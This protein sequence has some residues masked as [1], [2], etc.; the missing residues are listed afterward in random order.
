M[1]I[2]AIATD[3]QALRNKKAAILA[4]RKTIR[5]QKLKPLA[6]QQSEL[7]NEIRQATD[8]IRR[9][10]DK[11][12]K[13]QLLVIAEQ[14]K[15]VS[16]KRDRKKARK[17]TSRIAIDYGRVSRNSETPETV[18]QLAS[19]LHEKSRL[20]ERMIKEITD[21]KRQLLISLT[22]AQLEDLHRWNMITVSLDL[23]QGVYL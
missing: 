17:T 10:I 9:Q 11:E 21:G 4:E 6:R 2:Q 20:L 22:A 1:N 7:E 8:E 14:L 15:L 23:P 12:Q 13:Q 19:E 18:R 16:W 5:D 3:R